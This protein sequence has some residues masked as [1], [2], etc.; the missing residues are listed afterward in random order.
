MLTNQ[1]LIKVLDFGIAKIENVTLTQTGLVVGTPSYMAPEQVAGTKVDHRADIFALG[2]VF[3]ELVTREKPFR[4]DVVTIFYK[5]MDEDPVAPSLINPALPGGIDAIIRKALA[6]DP[7]ERFQ[8]CEEMR[9]AFLEQGALLNITAVSSVRAGTPVG[10]LAPSPPAAY[11]HYLLEDAA[12]QRLARIWPRLGAGLVVALVGATSWAFYT[13]S[14]T[15]SFRPI[16]KQLVGAFHPA[17]RQRPQSVNDQ[18]SQNGAVKDP[19]STG[20]GLAK[21]AS[22]APN[23]AEGGLTQTATEGFGASSTPSQ[24]SVAE[25]SSSSQ[26]VSDGARASAAATSLPPAQQR[27][28]A[29]QSSSAS[30]QPAIARS[31]AAVQQSDRNQAS[32]SASSPNAHAADGDSATTP[33]TS[34]NDETQTAAAPSTTTRLKKLEP[35]PAL[36]VDGFGRRDV[37]ELLRQADAAAE[38]GNYRLAGY[39]Y[40]LILKLDRSNTTARTGLRRVQ[41]AKQSQ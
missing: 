7:K 36:M 5:I 14:Q 39:E 35:E 18:T 22:A 25:Q 17:S 38:R 26:A 30:D 20:T 27:M 37:P 16:V 29:P 4:G 34:A 41:A 6:K 31:P 2:S 3:Y 13:R 32:E 23:G 21:Q 10:K 15:G 19:T 40:N 1:G 9:S 11:P 24:Q 12:P 33:V 8:T 28:P